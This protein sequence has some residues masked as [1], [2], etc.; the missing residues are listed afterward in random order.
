MACLRRRRGDS[1]YVILGIFFVGF[2]LSKYFN[3]KTDESHRTSKTEIE[4]VFMTSNSTVDSSDYPWF[5][6]EQVLKEAQLMNID[7]SVFRAN[8]ENKEEKAEFLSFIEDARHPCYLERDEHAFFAPLLGL[9]PP[10]AAER[11]RNSHKI[12]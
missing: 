3:F 2:L 7:L 1:F 9:N 8:S 10:N 11:S 4:N 12:K 6:T 5:L